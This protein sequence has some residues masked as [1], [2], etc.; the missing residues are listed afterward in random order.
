MNA[1]LNLPWLFLF[2]Q[3]NHIS[4]HCGHILDNVCCSNF[5]SEKMHVFF[6]RYQ[7]MADLKT[8]RFVGTSRDYIISVNFPLLLFPLGV[9]L[10]EKRH[11]LTKINSTSKMSSHFY[12]TCIVLSFYMLWSLEGNKVLQDLS[13][14]VIWQLVISKTISNLM[15]HYKESEMCNKPC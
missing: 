10:V 7:C 12:C 9:F 6:M 8:T 4:W 2:V 11:V 3:L 1:L 14:D 5:W 15:S 13:E